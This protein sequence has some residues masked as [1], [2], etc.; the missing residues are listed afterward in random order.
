MQAACEASWE[1]EKTLQCLVE[2]LETSRNSCHKTKELPSSSLVGLYEPKQSPCNASAS[3]HQVSITNSVSEFQDHTFMQEVPET[4]YHSERESEETLKSYEE[5]YDVNEDYY[6]SSETMK[7]K[8][9]SETE[10]ES[11]ETLEIDEGDHDDDLESVARDLLYRSD[12]D[13]SQEL[14]AAAAMN[15]NSE[16]FL[17]IDGFEADETPPKVNEGSNEP[18]YTPP[19]LQYG[20]QS[21]LGCDELPNVNTN[22]RFCNE[23]STPLGRGACLLCNLILPVVDSIAH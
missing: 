5:D 18:N 14:A 6:E 19:E 16:E 8:N 13:A 20:A 12:C 11:E 15:E 3:N 7:Y 10:M 1:A 2:Y 23:T 17:E 21:M 22:M 4:S 9:S